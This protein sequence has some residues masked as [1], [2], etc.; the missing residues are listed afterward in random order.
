MIQEIK[1]TNLKNVLLISLDKFEDFRGEYI[2]MYNERNFNERIQ[3]HIGFPLRFVEDDI[4]ISTKNVFKGI[5]GDDRTWKLISC[6]YGKIYV[7]V[8]NWDTK[9]EQFGQSQGFTLSDKN[10]LQLLVPPNH[11]NGHLCLSDTSIFAY[12]QTHYY[13]PHNQFTIRYN[14][15]DLKIWLPI[16]HPIVSQRD[17]KGDTKLREI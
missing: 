15:E 6:S 8:I 9:S 17:E 4:S 14:D 11:G 10:R 5:H 3:D 12:K 13:N 7:I 1:K 16:K 2:E